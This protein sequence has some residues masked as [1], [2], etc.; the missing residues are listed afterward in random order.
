M[1]VTRL[2]IAFLLLSAVVAPIAAQDQSQNPSDSRAALLVAERDKKATETTPPQRGRVERALYRYDQENGALPFIFQTW[3]GL[4]L[5]SGG[6]PAG[7]GTGFGTRYTH[8]LGSVRPAADPDRA[9]R[10][11]LDALAAYS[12]RSY[13]RAAVAVNFYHVAGAPVDVSL[14]AQRYEY[15]QEDFFGFGQDSLEENRTNYLL[16]STEAGAAARWKIA[17]PSMAISPGFI[18]WRW[19]AT[20]RPA[21]LAPKQ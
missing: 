15:P 18:D 20:N 2:W 5:A 7:A 1:S 11:E 21:H 10:V 14:R 3:H 19:N 13:W 16:R 12:T 17:L 8:G 6:F 9:N 4:Q